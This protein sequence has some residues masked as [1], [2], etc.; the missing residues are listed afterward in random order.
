MNDRD[1]SRIARD[2]EAATLL[3]RAGIH[4]YLAVPLSARGIVLG[5]LDLKR[6][7]NPLPFNHD[8]AVWPASLPTVPR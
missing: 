6:A 8:D 5:A 2:P 3:A 4:S 7:R 1:L